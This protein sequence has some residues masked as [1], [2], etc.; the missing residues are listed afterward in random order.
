MSRLRTMLKGVKEFTFTS[1]TGEEQKLTLKTLTAEFLPDVMFVFGKM[2]VLEGTDTSDPVEAGKKFMEAMDKETIA[3][4]TELC[5][6]TLRI[7]LPDEED[8]DIDQFTADHFI[9]LFMAVMQLNSP[10]VAN[11]KNPEPK[12]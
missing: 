4:A 5:K 11:A 1:D 6:E 7:S 10:G 2:S 3:V 8:G 12:S 9:P